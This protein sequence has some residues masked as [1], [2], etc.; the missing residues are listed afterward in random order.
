MVYHALV[1]YA[2]IRKSLNTLQ[3]YDSSN[4]SSLYIYHFSDPW[5][6]HFSHSFHWITFS[7]LSWLIF[8]YSF[9]ELV[10]GILRWHGKQFHHASHIFY[11]KVKHFPQRLISSCYL[12]FLLILCCKNTGS[13]I[14]SSVNFSVSQSVFG[15]MLSRTFFI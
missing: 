7:T 9:S 3:F 6:P 8:L 15:D 13:I 12:Y 4:F 10:L 11:K 1:V 14:K 5:N 2:Y